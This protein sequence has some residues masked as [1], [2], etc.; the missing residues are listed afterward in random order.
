MGRTSEDTVG[1]CARCRHARIITTPRSR[2]WL[3]ALAATD[4]RFVRYPRLPV[5]S[6]E[7]HEPLP[8][9]ESPPEGPSGRAEK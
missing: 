3:C 1:L 2:F 6:C 8:P 9:G 4:D 5:V 7:G